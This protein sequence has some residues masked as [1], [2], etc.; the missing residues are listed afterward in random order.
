[1]FLFQYNVILVFFNVFFQYN[2]IFVLFLFFC[3]S[4]FFSLFFF[5]SDVF[6]VVCVLV[7]VNSDWRGEGRIFLF[8]VD[9]F[10]G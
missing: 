8:H 1:M 7:F 3:F 6:L 2:V 4:L 5:V 9:V 10:G